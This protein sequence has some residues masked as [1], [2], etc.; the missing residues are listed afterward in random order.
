M[1]IFPLSI[2]CNKLFFDGCSVFAFL[3]KGI[4]K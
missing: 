4:S 1:M 3:M 2:D